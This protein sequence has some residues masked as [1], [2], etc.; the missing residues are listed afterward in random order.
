MFI[1]FNLWQYSQKGSEF[2]S[3]TFR[4]K[5]FKLSWFAKQTYS[6]ENSAQK[7]NFKDKLIITTKPTP[8]TNTKPTLRSEWGGTTNFGRII[9]MSWSFRNLFKLCNCLN[10]L[11]LSQAKAILVYNTKSCSK[12]GTGI[13]I[14]TF[15][16]YPLCKT[17]H[18]KLPTA[19]TVL[20]E[21][22]CPITIPFKIQP[23]LLG[24]LLFYLPIQKHWKIVCCLLFK[25][26]I[27]GNTGKQ[28]SK[29]LRFEF[30]K[31]LGRTPD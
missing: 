10:W 12:F 19:K 21:A 5:C 22:G 24:F 7:M 1:I 16:R 25:C 27:C 29:S 31:K 23:H 28:P 11:S 4:K 9:K 6:E 17:V 18:F 20:T 3:E 2:C 30:W 15:S 26:Y 14:F 13:F 8:I